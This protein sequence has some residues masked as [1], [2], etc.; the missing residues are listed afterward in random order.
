MMPFALICLFVFTIICMAIFQQ[1]VKTI[2]FFL[3]TASI[4]IGTAY[5]AGRGHEILWPKK[6]KELE[7]KDLPVIKELDDVIH[8]I[9]NRG[10]NS[11]IILINAIKKD[12]RKEKATKI[13]ERYIRCKNSP[14]CEI[15]L[16]KCPLN[17]SCKDF[18][19]TN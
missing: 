10:Y 2:V 7:I 14:R 16:Q 1:P 11:A 6:K 5:L 19:P 4:C 9:E 18:W 3:I 8:H 15:D 13:G 17:Y 12:L